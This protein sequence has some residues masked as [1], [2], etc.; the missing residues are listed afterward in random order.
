MSD[1]NLE[2]VDIARDYY[3]SED[4][5]NFYSTIW[6]GE[7][8]HVG[9][10]LSDND[11]IFDASRR[12]Q[13]RMLKQVDAPGAD[14]R[15]IDLGSG[16]GGSAR[17]LADRYGCRVTALNLSE[18]ENER[19]RKLNREQGLDELIEVVDGNFEE[20]PYEDETFDLVW[21]QDAFLH[22][23]ARE[24]V[25]KEASRVLKPGG[26]FVFTDPMQSDD[27]PEGVLQP[28]LNRIH[29]D[30]MASPEFYRKT[31]S[32]YNLEE[33]AFE[34]LTVHL[35]RHYS[36]VLD[37]TIKHETELQSRVSEEYIRNMKTGLQHWIDGAEKSY[38]AWGIFHFKKS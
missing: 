17:F 11:T 25:I 22:S 7:D 31:A 27:C 5:D 32:T 33:V 16:Y 24:Q 12:T 35:K 18:V 6:G 23:P 20:L 14:S 19:A 30:S 2:A 37:E 9:L 28:I 8:I 26:D 13:E 36:A 15:V 3:N 4:A 21:S 29:L 34:E 38:L 10:Y 1:I